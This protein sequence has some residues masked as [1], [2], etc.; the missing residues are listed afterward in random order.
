MDPIRTSTS[1]DLAGTADAPGTAPAG[2]WKV[3]VVDSDDAVQSRARE[4]L[5]SLVVDGRGVALFSARTI[6]SAEA[7]VREHPDL[8]VLMLDASGF[9]HDDVLGLVGEARR[10]TSGLVRLVLWSDSPPRAAERA[11]IESFGA[12]AGLAKV[13]LDVDGLHLGAL[14]ALRVH[15]ELSSRESSRRAMARV[16]VATGGLF[17]LKSSHR[18][19]F[20]CLLQLNSLLETSHDSLLCV[21]GDEDIDTDTIIIRAGTGRFATLTDAPLDRL[22]DAD[23]SAAVREALKRGKVQTDRLLAVSLYSRASVTAVAVIEVSRAFSALDMQMLEIFR[24]KASTVFSSFVLANDLNTI[25]RASVQALA[26]VAEYKDNGSPGHLQRVERLSTEVARE[27][28]RRGAFADDI[29]HVMIERIGLASMLHDV[30]MICVPD[31]IIRRPQPLSAEEHAIIRRHTETGGQI[32]S[33]AASA[34]RDRSLLSV[35]ADIARTHHERFDG[36]GYPAALSGSD[37][38]LS[39]RIVAVVDVFDA[40]VTDRAYRKAMPTSKAAEWVREQA[41]RQFDPVVTDAF[42]AV[43]ARILET[44]PEWPS[45]AG[46]EPKATGARF[47]GGFLASLE[48]R[49]RPRG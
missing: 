41:G 21:R 6:R 23:L 46:A 9:A 16:M 31:E 29:D 39:G 32:L 22:D 43:I 44:D 28:Y 27:L 36:S 49:L 5:A 20:N 48:Q 19:F 45:V 25:Q 42:L 8:A 18:F 38:P 15:A 7:A 47:G 10:A 12:D 17:E 34:L 14:R 37:I 3:L 4:G 35:A 40:L 30:G 11:M 33:R 24:T 26:H 1:G 13:G 2:R